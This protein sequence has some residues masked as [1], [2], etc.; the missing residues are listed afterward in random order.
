LEQ[1]S[2]TESEIAV[3][4]DDEPEEDENLVG[5]EKL[6]FAEAQSML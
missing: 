1:P 2:L 5:D 3:M 4:D 6:S